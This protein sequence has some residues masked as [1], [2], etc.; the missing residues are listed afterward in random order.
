MFGPSGRHD[1]I[2]G[3][4]LRSR[5]CQ[6]E[7]FSLS[8]WC[9]IYN[10]NFVYYSRLQNKHTPTLINVLTFFQGLQPR[11][12]ERRLHSGFHETEMQIWAGQNFLAA[13]IVAPNGQH[14]L[15]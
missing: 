14:V 4:L 2:V 5:L 7:P 3:L 10:L 1:T 13:H 8:L 15:S 9:F 6:K 12:I 11:P